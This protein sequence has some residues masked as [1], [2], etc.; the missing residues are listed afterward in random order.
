MLEASTPA[1]H[2]L[3]FTGLTCLAGEGWLHEGLIAAG[4]VTVDRVLGYARDPGKRAT[5]RSGPA[6]LRLAH[7]TDAD[8]ILAINAVAFE[9]FWRYD[10]AAILS[11]LLT[12]DYPVLAELAGRPIG[13]AL[14]NHNA[15][16]DYT[17]LIRVAVLPDYRGRGIGRQLVADAIN[18]AFTTHSAGLAL[19]TQASN[20]AS[21]R[22]YD[23]LGFI[24]TGQTLAVMIL[25]V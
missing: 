13:F 10:D 20:G 5:L 3:G 9:P 18:Y 1:L 11:W 24:P 4:L 15:H 23:S 16:T 6:R 25:P 12:S 8:T 7:S 2:T 22:L 17:Y 21:R 19:N 14:T